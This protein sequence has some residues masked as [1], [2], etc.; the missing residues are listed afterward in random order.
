MCSIMISHFRNIKYLARKDPHL[1][2]TGMLKGLKFKQA[3]ACKSLIVALSISN[4][5][6]FMYGVTM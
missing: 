6:P 3:A 5:V 1:T 2:D 4:I